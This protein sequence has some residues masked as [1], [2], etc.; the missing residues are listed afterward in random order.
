MTIIESLKWANDKLKTVNIDSPMLDAEIILAHILKISKPVLFAKF[1]EKLKTYEEEMFTIAIDKRMKNMPVAYIIG[2]KNFYNKEF[3]VNKN[4][5]IPRPATETLINEALKILQT[6]EK[7]STLICDIGTGSGI[8]AIT[9]SDE[10]KIPVIATDINETALIIAKQNAIKHNIND[11]DFQKGNLL[12]PVID[13]FKKLYNSNNPKIS[14][15]Y[16]FKNLVICA[17]LPYLNQ[18]QMETLLPSV[19]YEPES[20]LAAGIDGMDLYW[21][22]FKQISINR[23][24]LPRNVHT[25][26]EIDP[27]QSQGIQKLIQHHFPASEQKIIKDLEKHDRIVVNQI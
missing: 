1:N 17:N 5:L 8:I 3:K 16:P 25:I 14:S 18:K 26:I 20:A 21:K 27:S 22:L 9:L 7:D 2:K 24:K 23:A 11:I 15:V 10:T 4:V 6:M 12:E 13:L 19:K